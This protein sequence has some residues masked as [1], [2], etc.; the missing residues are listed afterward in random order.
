MYSGSKSQLSAVSSCPPLPTPL[1]RRAASAGRREGGSLLTE[2]CAGQDAF[3]DGVYD[4]TSIAFKCG[5]RGG[6]FSTGQN[7]SA[8]FKSGVERP[9]NR[10]QTREKKL[11]PVL[12]ESG[13]PLHYNPWGSQ[14]FSDAAP[15]FAGS[16]TWSQRGR[17]G[18][19]GTAWDGLRR[20]PSFSSNVPSKHYTSTAPPQRRSLDPKFDCFLLKSDDRRQAAARNDFTTTL[21]ARVN[22]GQLPPQ[23]PMSAINW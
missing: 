21:Q 7:Y 2:S 11:V 19:I 14:S 4:R 10:P 15:L 17:T 16:V 1:K 6:K 12:G 5:A 9:W 8:A 18:P 22:Y 13:G 23:R 3:Y 20:S